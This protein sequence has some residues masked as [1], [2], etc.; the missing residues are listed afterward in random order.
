MEI[1]KSSNRNAVVDNIKAIGIVLVIMGHVSQQAVLSKWIYSF[2]MPL[3]FFISG[4]MFMFS[5]KEAFLVR[6]VKSILVPYFCF[7]FLSL[8]Y[9]ALLESKFRHVTMSVDVL[10]QQVVSLLG[11]PIGGG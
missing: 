3:F 8:V 6:K 7:G 1:T 11:I 5:R 2:H 9:W 10:K 4:C